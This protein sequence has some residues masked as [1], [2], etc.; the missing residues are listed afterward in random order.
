MRK[1][2]YDDQYMQIEP[3]L[4]SLPI[5]YEE[6]PYSQILQQIKGEPI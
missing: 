5:Y 4:P 6:V 3:Y 2:Q 1:Y